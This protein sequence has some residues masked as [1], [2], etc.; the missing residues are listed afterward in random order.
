MTRLN[1]CLALLVGVHV[2]NTSA[3]G[4]LACPTIVASDVASLEHVFRSCGAGILQTE[5]VKPTKD[6]LVQLLLQSGEVT[7]SE[8]DFGFTDDCKF[9][10]TLDSLFSTSDFPP[11]AAY[12]FTAKASVDAEICLAGAKVPCDPSDFHHVELER[13]DILVIDPVRARFRLCDAE[14]AGVGCRTPSHNAGE[15]LKFS[16]S[17]FFQLDELPAIRK[18]TEPLRQ[19]DFD[20][21]RK[22]AEGFKSAQ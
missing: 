3:N 1:F 13:N 8:N 7:N 6:S 22:V 14:R 11:F 16:A 17:Q 15:L 4:L 9:S 18:I 10:P 20:A 19:D 21:I 2:A 5:N 12:L